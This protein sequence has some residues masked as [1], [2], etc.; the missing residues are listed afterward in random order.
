[1]PVIIVVAYVLLC[2]HI[3]IIVGVSLS[4]PHTHETVSPAIYLFIFVCII[5]HSVNKYPHVLSNSL[6][7]FDFAMCHQ[8]HKYATTF[9]N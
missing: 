1:M 2:N 9:N 7:S 4:E 3:I 5:R 8:F 6:D